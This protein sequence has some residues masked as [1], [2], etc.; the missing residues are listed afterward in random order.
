MLWNQSEIVSLNVIIHNV[1]R[2]DSRSDVFATVWFATTG[3]PWPTPF[4]RV[5]TSP[6]NNQWPTSRTKVSTSPDHS[7]RLPVA[8]S[9]TTRAYLP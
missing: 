9:P 3:S 2:A 1:V 7:L 8:D 6:G 4:E 5:S